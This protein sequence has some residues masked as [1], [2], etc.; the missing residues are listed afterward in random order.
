MFAV[1]FQALQIKIAALYFT[2]TGVIM[3]RFLLLALV[4]LSAAPAFADSSDSVASGPVTNIHTSRKFGIGVG[5]GSFAYGVS[6]KLFLGNQTAVQASVGSYWLAGLAVGV[7]GLFLG[8]Q[9]W[10]NGDLSLNWEAGAG[11]D[12]LLGTGWGSAMFGA[13]G[14]AGL[15]LQFRPF[16][17]EITTDVR[18]GFFFVD[19]A[20]AGLSG[21]TF[22][23]GGAVRYYF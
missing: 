21:F 9:I 8:N 17:L 23:Y 13:H 2:F 1:Q 20:F 16:P 7:D 19:S 6:G 14:L 3:R 15:S 5:G 4:G 11:A 10:T 22:F 12:A 18:P